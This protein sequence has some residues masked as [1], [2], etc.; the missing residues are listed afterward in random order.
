MKIVIPSASNV[1]TPCQRSCKQRLPWLQRDS[2]LPMI[3][4]GLVGRKI[5]EERTWLFEGPTWRIPTP[6]FRLSRS[7]RKR[8]AVQ[9]HHLW[10]QHH[11]ISAMTKP[12]H[13]DPTTQNPTPTINASHP[14]PQTSNY[15]PQ[16][17]DIKL[18]TPNPK[19]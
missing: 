3:D 16:H 19:H 5:F 10:V 12:Q 6:V 7:C 17:L 1:T 15:K 8:A 14:K 11:D 9:I 13:V 4:S 18:Q 2:A